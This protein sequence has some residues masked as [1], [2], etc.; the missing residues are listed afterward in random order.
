MNDLIN[1]SFEKY[2]LIPSVNKYAPW[3]TGEGRTSALDQSLQTIGPITG[4]QK[5]EAN[6]DKG[7]LPIGSFVVQQKTMC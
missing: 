7:C 3:K 5:P 2:Q 6:F 1:I 4:R